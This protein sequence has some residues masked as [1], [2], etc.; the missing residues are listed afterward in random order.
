MTRPDDLIQAADDCLYAGK[1][2]G[3]NRVVTPSPACAPEPAAA[4]S[5][6]GNAEPDPICR[7]DDLK[8]VLAR[9]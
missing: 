1:R 6:Q 7:P 4:L 5:P 2:A 8:K 3:R 9:F